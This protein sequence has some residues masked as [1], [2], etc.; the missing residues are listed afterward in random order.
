MFKRLVAGISTMAIMLA[1]WGTALAQNAS[2]VDFEVV[3]YPETIA[4]FDDFSFTVRA[5]DNLGDTVTS[6]TGT[7]EFSAPNDPNA[8]LPTEYEFAADDQGE[9]IF[10][11]SYYFTEAGAQSLIITDKDNPDLS[12]TITINVTDEQNPVVDASQEITLTSPTAGATTDSTI[13]VRGQTTPGVNV[14]I[15]NGAEILG[16]IDA[17]ADGN[18]E[19][20]T[21]VLADGS[22]NISAETDSARS[23]SINVIINTSAPSVDFSE[24]TPEIVAPGGNFKL[25]IRLD[26]QARTVKAIVNGVQLGLTKDEVDPKVFSATIPAPTTAGSY[27]I[28]LRIEDDLG[29]VSENV[30]LGS[31]ITVSTS[32]TTNNS[33]TPNAFSFTVPSQVVNV[34][35]TTSDKR[36]DLVW[37]SATAASGIKNYIVYYGVDPS[38]LGLKVE[39]NGPTPQWYIPNLANGQTYYFQ[40]YAV[41][42]S[43]NR[44]DLGSQVVSAVPSLV[45]SNSLHGTA[46]GQVIVDQTSQTGPGGLAVLAASSWLSA[47]FIRRRRQK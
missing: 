41:D 40:I 25:T 26:A 16:N 12:T 8:E 3:D 35:G 46:E 21:S 32:A 34:R 43:G 19:F 37:D 30:N 10:S 24:L 33:T 27:G 22:Y 5:I 38:N 20:T 47:G 36:V 1:G 18:F 15:L 13:T 29:N 7:V 14:R 2:V 9:K 28:T 11:E 6:Y 44:S 31:S 23:S 45:G 17:N 39:T 42:N 4:S